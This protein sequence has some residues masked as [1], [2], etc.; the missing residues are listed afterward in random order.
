[1]TNNT[2]SPQILQGLLPEELPDD[3]AK[4]LKIGRITDV[5]RHHVDPKNRSLSL[6]Q[7]FALIQAGR[8]Q[9]ALR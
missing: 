7:G 2:K 8:Y 5:L 9:D 3:L 6:L 1:M 4:M